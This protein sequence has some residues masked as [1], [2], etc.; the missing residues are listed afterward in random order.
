MLASEDAYED[1]LKLI[2]QLRHHDFLY[3]IKCQPEISDYA[4]DQLYRKL[5]DTEKKHPSWVIPSSPSQS[6][7]D[8]SHSG[9]KQKLHTA[10]M[11]S[12]A[13]TYNQEEVEEFIHRVK[14]GLEKEH[15][16]FCCELKMDGLAVSIRYENGVLVRA[17][18]RGD[19]KTG[20]DVT[21]NMKAIATLPFRLKGD[22]I[23]KVLEI[24]GEVF[25]PRSIF[26]KLNEEKKRKNEE[27]YANPRNAAAGSLKLLDYKEVYARGLQ[28]VGYGIIEDSDHQVDSQYLVHDR[29]KSL[30]IPSFHSEHR[31]KARS[32]QEIFEFADRIE[33]ERPT[34]DYDIDGIVIKLDRIKWQDQLGFTA[35]IPRF[36]VAYKFHAEKAETVIEAVTF[37]VGRT[38]VITPV[39][40]LKPVFLAGSTISR[41]TL[42]NFDEVKRKDIHI[43]DQ[44][45]IEKG[46][47][48][49]PKVVE[50]NRA[51]RPKQA[52]P[53]QEPSLCPS[54]HHRLQKDH[55]L[56][57]L[58]CLNHEDCPMQNLRKLIYFASKDGMEIEEMGKKVVEKLVESG[59]LK[60]FSDFFLLE[61]EDFL[62]L[63]G[64]QEKSARN[65]Y[66]RIQKAKKTTLP[67][68]L[69][70]IGIPHVGKQMADLLAEK[71]EGLD[72]LGLASREE[73]L[74][75]EGVG[76][77]VADAILDYFQDAGHKKELKRLIEFG[78]EIQ[79]PKKKTNRKESLFLDKTV[80]LT[81]TLQHF[82]RKEAED[83]LK[84][85][86]AKVSASVSK[87]T[88]YVIYGEEPGSKLD[89]ARLLNVKTL[90]ESEFLKKI[91][92]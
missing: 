72:Q 31:L 18:T 63:P 4:Y 65:L 19:G 83:L 69:G 24:R 2:D 39:A 3:Y 22:S 67:K 64:F 28:V 85:L 41:A 57:A 49:I 52:E 91:P 12:L 77:K 80:V 25:M 32:L 38:G 42:H 13:N 6:I 75:I 81:G 46:G 15:V 45:V 68:L 43:Y 10:P 61:Q 34:L 40:E 50:V 1:Y 73:L 9:F 66:E 47:D 11:L 16:E 20:D 23:P 33:K 88:D 89:K 60:S 90:S 70:A 79:L 37:Q 82:K 21:H 26:R 62:E 7:Q 78:V 8:S 48:V 55:E 44:V 27:L 74:S 51:K 58:R 71:F 5:L 76:E 29:L 84:E 87:S 17:L 53:V 35:K 54:C 92:D 14:K 59:K 86:G 56:V 30:G 36:A